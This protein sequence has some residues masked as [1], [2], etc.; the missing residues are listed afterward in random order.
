MS[1]VRITEALVAVAIAVAALGVGAA[2]VSTLQT[3]GAQ[4]SLTE[5][6]SVATSPAARVG[7]ERAL[8]VAPPFDAHRRAVG[9]TGAAG[10]AAT[11][12]V[13]VGFR[14]DT[15]LTALGAAG[16]RA[17]L[18]LLVL[19]LVLAGIM[20]VAGNAPVMTMRT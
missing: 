6:A 18:R 13:R 9:D 8:D 14:I 12:V 11:A 4:T 17:L 10:T 15:A 3:R 1:D 19:A 2:G 16:A 7:R 5:F 20:A